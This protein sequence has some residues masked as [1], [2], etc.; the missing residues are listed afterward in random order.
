M[1]CL[2]SMVGLWT[3]DWSSGSNQISTL[4]NMQISMF[5]LELGVMLLVYLEAKLAYGC[6]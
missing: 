3:G 2:A 6:A 4:R 1:A 5:E